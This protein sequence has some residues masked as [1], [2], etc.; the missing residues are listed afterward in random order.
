MKL[1]QQSALAVQRLCDN[2]EICG[3]ARF[4]FNEFFDMQDFLY[5]EDLLVAIAESTQLTD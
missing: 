4:V 2:H 1:A 3:S 5:Q